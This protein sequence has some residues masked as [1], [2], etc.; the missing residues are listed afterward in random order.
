MSHKQI[1]VHFN[2]NHGVKLNTYQLIKKISNMISN[3][4]GSFNF[5]FILARILNGPINFESLFTITGFFPWLRESLMEILF[6]LLARGA[7]IQAADSCISRYGQ[8]FCNLNRMHWT[9]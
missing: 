7:L 2:R 6:L 3:M 8:T 1:S 4:L 5:A 9:I